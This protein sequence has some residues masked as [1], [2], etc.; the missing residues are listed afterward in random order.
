[1]GNVT[2]VWIHY[3]NDILI[4]EVVNSIKIS[5]SCVKDCYGQGNGK[6]LLTNR[7]GK[8]IQFTINYIENIKIIL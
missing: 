4:P 6:Y 2:L 1:M 8:I 3:K 7:D 5:S